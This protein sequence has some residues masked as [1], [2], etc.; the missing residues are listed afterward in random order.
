MISWLGPNQYKM[1]C[2]CSFEINTIT[3]DHTR[4]TL[5]I[6]DRLRKW[7]H[8]NWMCVIRQRKYIWVVTGASFYATCASANENAFS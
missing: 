3:D 2:V 8:D 1:W 6:L 7:M 4:A 5:V